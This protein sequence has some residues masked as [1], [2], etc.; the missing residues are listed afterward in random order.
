[1]HLLF[2]I[3]IGLIAIIIIALAIGRTILSRQFSKEVSDLF[4]NA[5][6]VSEKLFSYEQLDSLPT[7]VQRYFK[8]ILPP[9]Q[10]YI[11]YV[12]LTHDGQFKS[13]LK[14]GWV[15]IEGEEYFTTEQPGFIWKGKTNLFTARDMYIGNQGRLVVSLLSLFKVVDQTGEKINQGELL[16]WLSESVWFPTNLLP[17]EN[18][19]WEPIDSNSA[20]LVYKYLDLSVSFKV[21]FNHI[22][23]IIQMETERYMANSGLERWVV[24]CGH[25]QKHGGVLIPT[26]AEVLW[27]LKAEDFS[28]AKFNIQKIAYNHPKRFSSAD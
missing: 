25:Y 5:K 10:P 13:G 17:S 6:S 2:E 20:M 24:K 21:T 4:S 14:K 27:R 22:G 23:E 26:T 3:A 1:M 15:K 7:P 16:R 8:L 11:S 19:R 18:L 28:Y 12:R 9:G